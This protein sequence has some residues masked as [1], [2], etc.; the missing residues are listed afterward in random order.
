MLMKRIE[1]LKEYYKLSSISDAAFLITLLVQG[2]EKIKRLATELLQE[3]EPDNNWKYYPG[4]GA[5]QT[6]PE[7]MK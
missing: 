3:L 6:P 4:R 1:V 7:D 5:W 2:P